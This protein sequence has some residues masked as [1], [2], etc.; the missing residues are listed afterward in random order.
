MLCF[1]RKVKLYCKTRNYGP[2]QILAPLAKLLLS[3]KINNAPTIFHMYQI[4]SSCKT[5]I[6]LYRSVCLRKCYRVPSILFVYT[7]TQVKG[8]AYRVRV[9]AQ[10]LINLFNFDC[11]LVPLIS[12][13]NF[14]FS[15]CH[16]HLALGVKNRIQRGDRLNMIDH[17]TFDQ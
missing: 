2:I 6:S 12:A 10:T 15:Q 17:N 3:A 8:I 4:M 5:I 16:L 14:D 11:F 9:S 13:L 7:I 1:C